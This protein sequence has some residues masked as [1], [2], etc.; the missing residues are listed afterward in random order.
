MR[1]KLRSPPGDTGGNGVIVDDPTGNTS[2]FVVNDDAGAEMSFNAGPDRVAGSMRMLAEKRADAFGLLR[3]AV[4]EPRFDKAP[5][6]RIRAQIAN[7]IQANSR[8]P[9]TLAAIAFAKAVYG[10]HPYSRRSEG[11]LES[12]VA[13]TP[14]DVRGVHKRIFARDK[15][16]IGVVGAIDAAT[17]KAELDRVFG[18]LPAKADLVPI[19]TVAPKFAQEVHID[20]P[21]PQ[22]SVQL[23]YPGIDRKDDQFFAAY[24]MNHILGAGTFTSRLFSEVREKRG[25]AYG[26]SSGLSNPMYSASLSI[27][28]RTNA[29][30]AD[31][32]LKVIKEV[33]KTMAETGPTDAEL[34]N[35]KRYVV[36]S[37]AINNLDSSGAI[38][39][40]LVQLQVE[41]LGI[42]YIDRREQLINSVTREQ[43]AAVAKRLLSAE[44]AVLSLGPAKEGG[45]NG[46][47]NQTSN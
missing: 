3:L 21:L 45:A 36:G 29:N 6:D 37:Y 8:D 16:K 4:N 46:T 10:D 17:L 20:Y 44:P 25:L 15:L 13:L 19:A 12:L 43:A 23:A 5:F 35:A 33:V 38:A 32:T 1:G 22:T 27:S 14:D 31:E 11:S 40:T 24:L 2:P 39:N 47:G 30:R 7:G 34:A 42:D 18:S 28:T 41:D 26:V 9:Q